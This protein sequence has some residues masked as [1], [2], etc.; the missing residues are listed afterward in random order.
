M[1]VVVGCVGL[2]LVALLST[3]CWLAAGHSEQ[4]Q[5]QRQTDQAAAL[6]QVSV[7]QIE[8]PLATTVRA[9]RAAEGDDD[10]FAQLAGELLEVPSPSPYRS[11][12]LYDVDSASAIARAGAESKLASRPPDEIESVLARAAQ[13]QRM[14]VVDLLDPDRKLGFAVVDDASSPRYVL[15]AERQLSSDPNVRRRSDEAFAE[16]RYAIYLGAET[17]AALLGSSERQL[18]LDGRRAVATIPYGDQ[19]LV[20]VASPNGRLVDALTAN[21]WWIVALI[22]IV[23]TALGVLA[24]LRLNRRRDDAERLAAAE[25]QKH[26]EQRSI[27]ETLQ[28]GLLPQLLDVP[29]HTHIAS[30]YWPAGDAQLIGGDFWDVFQIDER[31]WGLLIGDVCGKGMEAAAMTS[32][33]RYTARAA[34]HLGARPADVLR[35]IHT[36]V[37]Q[38]HP[39]TF[40]TVCFAMYEPDG[41]DDARGHLVVTLGGHPR[42]LH[43]RDR[44]TEPVGRFGTILGMVEPSLVEDVVP[45]HDGDTLVMFTDGL[46]DAPGDQ[47]VPFGE[48][49]EL[50]SRAGDDVEVLADEIRVLKRRRRPSGSADDTAILI[51]RFGT[52]PSPRTA[53]AAA[54]GRGEPSMIPPGREP[55]ADQPVVS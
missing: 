2:G 35:S 52:S 15:Y 25:A 32:L 49:E 43:I 3:L 34:A 16:L 17:D 12:E 31:R 26:E 45:I 39:P 38:Q 36:A 8:S 11:I 42:P 7:A 47:A 10:L 21:L 18:P 30:R 50:F 27:A 37:T 53:V 22:G 20:L 4:R 33:V 51:V 6:L 19:T 44:G 5:L 14:A 13:A 1:P 28:L 46:T 29:P 48:L 54:P 40:C 9:V 23:A 41:P 24:V 55:T